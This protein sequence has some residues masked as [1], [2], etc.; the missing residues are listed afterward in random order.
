MEIDLD[1]DIKP[2]NGLANL[3]LRRN[4]AELDSLLLP[5]AFSQTRAYELVSLYEACYRLAM[6][7]VEVVADVRNGKVFRLTAREGYRGA[8]CRQ[9]RVGMLV[10]AAMQIESRLRYEEANALLVMEGVPGVAL[11]VDAVDPPPHIV[12]SLRI[13]A[14]SVYAGE[15][16]SREGQ[17]GLW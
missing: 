8:L 11:N 2:N 12:P 14:I 13:S 1:A 3:Q 4:I 16:D 15:I 7:A 5:L 10:S 17:Q 6:G 9:I